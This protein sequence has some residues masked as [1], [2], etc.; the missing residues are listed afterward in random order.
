MKGV[1]LLRAFS[2]KSFY[3]VLGVGQTAS[4]DEIKAA[5]L[6]LAKKFHPDSQ[7]GDEEKFKDISKA[8]QVLRNEE[9]RER[10]DKQTGKVEERKSKGEK[11]KSERKSTHSSQ[12]FHKR[13]EHEFFGTKW[14]GGGFKE[15][16]QSEMKDSV[17]KPA[18]VFV[19]MGMYAVGASGLFLIGYIAVLIMKPLPKREKVE[20][21]EGVVSKMP[22]RRASKVE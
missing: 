14:S 9:E 3:E 7:E 5:Y 4:N 1:R 2:E 21:P 12:G 18:D 15:A 20:R 17:I 22:E 13:Y 6:K 8:Y 10:Y 19:K 11:N 16:K